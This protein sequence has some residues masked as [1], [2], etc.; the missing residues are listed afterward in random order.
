M[1]K[2]ITYGTFDKL[3]YGHIRL[4]ERA[5]KLGD[6]L[7]VGVTSDDYDIARGKI[8]VQE[9]LIERIK[10]VKDT[11]LADEI[12]VEEYEGQ[13]IDDIQKYDIKVFAIGS[14]W[15]GKFDFLN[16]YCDV[17]YLER[18]MGVSSSQ[19]RGEERLVRIGI[20]GEGQ[21][22]TLRK[23]CD[24]CNYANGA[25]VTAILSDEEEVQGI[26]GIHYCNDYDE[27]NLECDAVYIDSK[28]EKHYQ[29]VLH[30]MENGKHVICGAPLCLSGEDSRKLYEY[31]KRHGLV[32]M[33]E[34][35]TAS[36]TAYNRLQ[37]IANSG[38]IGK[39]L[40]IDATCT[41]LKDLD[42][43]PS[44]WNS[45]CEWG[46]T[47]LLP[48]FQILG[49]RYNDIRIVT[50][51]L[52]N[53]DFDVFTKIDFLYSGATATVKVGNGMKSEGELIISGEKGYIYVPAP[54]W[55]TDYF[56]IRYENSNENKRYFYQLEGEGIRYEIV[57]FLKSIQMKKCFSKID[58][59]TSI[60]I[61][62]IMEKYYNNINLVK[63]T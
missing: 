37:L 30:A 13:K 34:I 58:E 19:L 56:E 53:T 26:D 33:E 60:A 46:P 17:V 32:L 63:L 28:P 49:N 61:S 4:L 62:S 20:M 21:A 8:N 22:V 14:D 55:K 51:R 45:I 15:K 25:K 11:G 36:S 41:S 44:T 27:L 16:K 18:T 24:E 47:A 10:G 31:A 42:N 57:S 2:V 35:K 5:K 3:H 40:S 6:Y 9:S 23:F 1:K 52:P 59:T 43:Q 50:K 38:V 39:I 29:D 12:I 48:V 7:I 54:W